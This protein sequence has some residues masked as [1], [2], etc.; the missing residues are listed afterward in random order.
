MPTRTQVLKANMAGR[1]QKQLVVIDHLLDIDAAFRPF[2][3]TC[4]IRAK[5]PKIHLPDCLYKQLR[6]VV[7]ELRAASWAEPSEWPPA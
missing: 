3:C 6:D 1:I 7:S 4:A 2:G 5:D